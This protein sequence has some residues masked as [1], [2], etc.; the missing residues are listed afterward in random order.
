MPNRRDDERETGRAGLDRVARER[1]RVDDGR[2]EAGEGRETV[3][4]AGG[5]AARERDAERRRPVTSGRQSAMPAGISASVSDAGVSQSS[6]NVSHSWQCGH[7]QMSSALR[8]R[9]RTHTCGSR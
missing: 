6:T 8:Y 2:A 5:D 1:V 9:Q 7:C 3:G 4:F